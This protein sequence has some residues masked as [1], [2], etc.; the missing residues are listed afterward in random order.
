MILSIIIVSYN[1]RDLTLQ[2]LDSVKE[3]VSSS[4]LLKAQTEVIVVDNNSSDESVSA[5][6]QWLKKNAIKGQVIANKDNKGFSSANNQGLNQAQGKY[7]LLLN[8]DTV[9]Q[10]EGL[11]KVVRA[12]EEHPIQES[13]AELSSQHGRLDKLGILAATL[14]NPDKTIQ[15]Q[16]GSFP[17]LLSLTTHLLLLDDLPL[18]GR[19]LPST[20][21]TGH[22]ARQTL[23]TDS[24]DLI[25]LDWVGGTAMMLRRE[26]IDEIGQLDS[27]IFMY[28]E[29]IEYCMRAR[30]HHWDVAIHPSAQIVHYGSASSTSANAIIGEL[31]SY[32]YIWAKH[33]P[34]TQLP[35]VRFIIRLG[36]ML[37]I[38]IFGTILGQTEKSRIYKRAL[39]EVFTS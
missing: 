12:F 13:T 27:N 3:N 2:T 19:F 36:I 7:V 1:T 20:Q 30:D 39:S 5:V 11:E 10:N 37:R 14:L 31:K 32:L 18:I 26:M 17:T 9:V 33:K 21:H 24:D 38:G 16:G 4:K 34:L 35:L 23:S 6:K 8:S 25:Q 15:A 22:N 28:G 29:D